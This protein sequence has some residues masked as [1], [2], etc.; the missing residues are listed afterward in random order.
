MM[1]DKIIVIAILFLLILATITDAIKDSVDHKKGAETLYGFWHLMKHL[2]R[3]E[4]FGT[5]ILFA[6]LVIKID[7]VLWNCAFIAGTMPLLFHLKDVVWNPFYKSSLWKII[8]N[9]WI[10]KTGL[11]WLDKKL[12]FDKQPPKG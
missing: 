10:I 3:L 7:S 5:G 6:L 12:G 4:I 11:K 1:K 2:L 9:T 8:D